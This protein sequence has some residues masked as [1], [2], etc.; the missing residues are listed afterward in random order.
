VNGKEKEMKHL[1][2]EINEF[3]M[4]INSQLFEYIGLFLLTSKHKYSLASVKTL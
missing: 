2:I 4:Q 3:Y 1:N